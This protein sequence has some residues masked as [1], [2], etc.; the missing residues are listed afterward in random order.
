MNVYKEDLIFP[1]NYNGMIDNKHE[2]Q[3]SKAIDLTQMESRQVE[4]LMLM[5]YIP[6][7]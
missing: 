6:V 5:G 4:L 2:I 7:G 1:G 3:M